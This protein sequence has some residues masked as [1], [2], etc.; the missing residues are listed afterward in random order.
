MND[1]G[2]SVMSCLLIVLLLLIMLISM[3]KLTFT[4]VACSLLGDHGAD[5]AYILNVVV[6]AK[7]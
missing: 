4:F 3:L 6:P 5:L 7:L 2:I 1:T